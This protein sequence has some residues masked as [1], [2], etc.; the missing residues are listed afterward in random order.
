VGLT[1]SQYSSADKIR[2]GLLPRIVTWVR[3]F[4][5]ITKKSFSFFNTHFDHQG[6]EGRQNSARLVRS[7]IG[8]IGVFENSGFRTIGGMTF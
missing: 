8:E 1:P 6:V 2:M 5:S 3:L 4:D 7:K